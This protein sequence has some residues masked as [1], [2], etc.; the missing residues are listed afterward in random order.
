M[1]SDRYLDCIDDDPRKRRA[2]FDRWYDSLPTEAD[3][4]LRQQNGSDYYCVG[5]AQNGARHSCQPL[6]TAV[7]SLE[8]EVVTRWLQGAYL[9]HDR[10]PLRV[11][12]D[13]DVWP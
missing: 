3:V 6:A 4:C 12:T 1:T 2:W 8:G 10:W 5:G 7:A 13:A 9:E 11:A